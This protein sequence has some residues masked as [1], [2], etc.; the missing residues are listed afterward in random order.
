MKQ[1]MRMIK[2]KNINMIFLSNSYRILIKK[3]MMR[4]SLPK[5]EYLLYL[6]ISIDLIG[7]WMR[8]EGYS[9]NIIT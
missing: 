4:Y 3:W 6:R 5:L 8:C 7:W 1:N 2:R 9:I